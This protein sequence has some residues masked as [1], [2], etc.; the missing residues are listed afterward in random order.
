[1]MFFG[2]AFIATGLESNVFV[3]PDMMIVGFIMVGGG[4][5]AVWLGKRTMRSNEGP[6]FTAR[7]W[8]ELSYK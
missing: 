7:Q 5:L 3:G 1:M 6:K 8:E 2:A 4:I